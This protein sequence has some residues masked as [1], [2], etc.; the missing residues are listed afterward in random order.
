MPEFVPD[1]PENREDSGFDIFV[2]KLRGDSA[3]EDLGVSDVA[4]A[5]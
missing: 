3:E 2:D 1:F 4:G 5:G